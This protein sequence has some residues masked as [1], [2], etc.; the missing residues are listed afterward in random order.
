LV[1]RSAITREG[2][3]R[4]TQGTVRAGY[5]GG[6]GY[7]SHGDRT[8]PSKARKSH[9]EEDAGAR[10]PKREPTGGKDAV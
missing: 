1:V 2:F 8:F 6:H 5:P 9:K 7:L 3:E 4:S 10:E